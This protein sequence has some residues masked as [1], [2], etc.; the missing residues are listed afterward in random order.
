MLFELSSLQL[1]IKLSHTESTLIHVETE[2]RLHSEATQNDASSSYIGSNTKSYN[3]IGLPLT[4]FPD[5]VTTDKMVVW[6]EEVK[7]GQFLDLASQEFWMR[8]GL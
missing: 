5:S 7:I 8:R 6:E 2:V 3:Y 4:N 1:A